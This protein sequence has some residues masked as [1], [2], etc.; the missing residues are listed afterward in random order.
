MNGAHSAYHSTVDGH[1]GCFHLWL[2]MNS[3]MNRY[4]EQFESLFSFFWGLYPEWNGWI[5]MITIFKL[6]R[7]CLFPTMP[8][9][10]T[11]K[12]FY[13]PTNSTPG[14]QFLDLHI[15]TC[16]FVFFIITIL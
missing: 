3:A 15:N 6:L 7:N 13:I 16:Y 10:D 14:F 9:P 1:L 4:M 12:R 2:V 11:L 5:I 8:A